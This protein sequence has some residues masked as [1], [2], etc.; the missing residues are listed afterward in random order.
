MATKGCR[1]GIVYW[2][3]RSYYDEPLDKDTTRYLDE[4]VYVRQYL[5]DGRGNEDKHDERIARQGHLREILFEWFDIDTNQWDCYCGVHCPTYTERLREERIKR[6]A[7][8][9]EMEARWQ[10]TRSA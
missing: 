1:G 7:E 3:K 10:H 5:K 4:L 8:T 2:N 6:E 9:P